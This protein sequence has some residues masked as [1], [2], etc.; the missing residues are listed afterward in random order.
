MAWGICATAG[1]QVS[2][3]VVGRDESQPLHSTQS[4]QLPITVQIFWPEM[5]HTESLKW[6]VERDYVRKCV[7]MMAARD[8]CESSHKSW[9][10]LTI[11]PSLHTTASA[12]LSALD[13]V[14][15]KIIFSWELF[16]ILNS[17]FTRILQLPWQYLHQKKRERRGAKKKKK[18]YSM[19]TGK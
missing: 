2:N 3:W 4:I 6:Q 14:I 11:P 8:L 18:K 1:W 7:V 19:F 16:Y 17:Y 10:S 15:C 5:R 12:F 9:N 13:L